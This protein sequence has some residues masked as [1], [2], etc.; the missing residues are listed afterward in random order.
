MK[1][2]NSIIAVFAIVL[3]TNVNAVLL[4]RLNG[5][6]YYDTEADLT[7]LADA[8]YSQTSGYDDDGLMGWMDAMQWASGLNI[9]GVTGWRL[10]TT[11]QPDATCSQENGLGSYGNNC[12]GSEMGNFYYNVLGGNVNSSVSIYHSF[13]ETEFNFYNELFNNVPVDFGFFSS[14][15]TYDYYNSDGNYRAFL[16][17]FYFHN[18]WQDLLYADVD[19]LHAWAVHS[20]DV[21]VVPLPATALLFLSG[22]AGLFGLAKRK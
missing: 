3:S 4:E 22:L 6:A 2:W 9:E 1:Y 14:T 7:W 8:N 5:L 15:I 13:Y 19:E 10:P 16:M 17:G 21:A 11:L 18:G 20:G 12:S